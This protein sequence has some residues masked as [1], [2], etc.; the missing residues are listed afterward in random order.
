MKKTH[1]HQQN[2]IGQSAQTPFINIIQK[3]HDQFVAS[4]RLTAKATVNLYSAYTRC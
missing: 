1:H 4:N 2:V 3:R